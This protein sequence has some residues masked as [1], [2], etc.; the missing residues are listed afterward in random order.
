MYSK[1]YAKTFFYIPS[2]HHIF[3]LDIYL[4]VYNFIVVLR[5]C[6]RYEVSSTRLQTKIWICVWGSVTIMPAFSIIS[7]LSFIESL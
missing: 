2:A 3:V 6:T 1:M 4:D 7:F 5:G